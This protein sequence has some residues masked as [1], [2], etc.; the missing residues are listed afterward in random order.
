MQGCTNP[1]N[2]IG[3]GTPID[4]ATGDAT[5]G[6]NKTTTPTLATLGWNNSGQVGLGFNSDQSGQTG[7][8]LQDVR[9]TIFNG[10][11]E[12]GSFDLA[13]NY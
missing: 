4:V 13:L 12:V 1:D 11:T 5:P 6:A 7:I 8:T 10:T 9:L 3:S 2:L